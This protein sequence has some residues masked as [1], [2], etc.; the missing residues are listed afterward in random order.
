MKRFLPAIT[1]FFLT[2]SL[3]ANHITGGQIF[4]AYMGMTGGNYN[5]NVTL[6]LYRDHAS[7]G[8]PLDD[9]ASIAIFDGTT[10]VWNNSVPRMDTIHL[11]LGSPG[12]C[13]NNPP[14]VWY[15]VGRYNF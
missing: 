8:A 1:S 11:H 10:M 12:P 15:E 4:Y 9:F 14:E 13:I 7:L 2:S 6:W 5:Y 3:F